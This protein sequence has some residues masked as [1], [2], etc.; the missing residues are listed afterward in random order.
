M[1]WW[2]KIRDVIE[3]A[4]VSAVKTAA[5]SAAPEIGKVL[6]NAGAAV[7]AAVKVH[8]IAHGSDDAIKA[9]L[10]SIRE[11]APHLEATVSTALAASVVAELHA[12]AKQDDPGPPPA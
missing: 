10:G 7:V 6:A 4:A 8:G 1:S 9:A 11:Q 5:A 3:H 2:T 12:A